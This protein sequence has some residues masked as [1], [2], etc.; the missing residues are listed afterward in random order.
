MIKDR[1]GKIK[2]AGF[3]MMAFLLVLLAVAYGCHPR[4]RA[5][6]YLAPDE[7]GPMDYK[8]VAG[9]GII[10][11]GYMKVAARQVRKGEEG[12]A[13]LARL[14]E[15]NFIIID[16]VIQNTSEK[17]IIY[18][19]NLTSL[20]ND[21]MDFLRPLDYTDL[22]DFGEFDALDEIRGRFYDLDVTLKPGQRSSRLLIFRPVSKN[23]K[24]AALNID[25]FYLGTDTLRLTFPF[26]FKA[27]TL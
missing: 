17:T 5:A 9:A 14:L 15:E 12:S 20:T 7:K 22:Y 24:K 25:D 16:L 23:A 18:K 26:S 3:R 8:A 1:E 10:E 2:T 21:A 4:P 6:M 11:N 13:L 19:P 27:R